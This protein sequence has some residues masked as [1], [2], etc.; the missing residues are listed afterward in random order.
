[1][2][3]VSRLYK[4]SV[5]PFHDEGYSYRGAGKTMDRPTLNTFTKANHEAQPKQVT[6]VTPHPAKERQSLIRELD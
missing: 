6:N 5:F 4:F 2:E 3:I 1:M